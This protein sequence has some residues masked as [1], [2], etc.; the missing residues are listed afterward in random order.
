MKELIRKIFV[1]KTNNTLIQLFR[2][3][4][5]GGTAFLVDFGLLAFLTEFFDLHYLISTSCG[6]LGGL[7]VNYIISILWV[8]TDSKIKNKKI[9]FL[10]FTVIGII[11]LLLT[12]LFMY[13]F[14]DIAEIHYLI[15]KIITTIIVYL[16]NF[17]GRKYILFSNNK[18]NNKNE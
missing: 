17:L 14:T 7:I 11:G 12:E 15:S 1:E 3:T 16:W 2:Y 8:F 10:I 9:E 18:K 4:F 13:L 5:V 6:F